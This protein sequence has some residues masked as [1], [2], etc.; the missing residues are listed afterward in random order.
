M[1][2]VLFLSCL[3]SYIIPIN[4]KIKQI[5]NL[6]ME[7]NMEKKIYKMQCMFLLLIALL[8]STGVLAQKLVTGKVTDK[9]NGTGIP[10]VSIVIVGTSQGTLTNI[11]GDYSLNVPSD[12]NEITFSMIGFTPQTIKVGE[13]GII[14]VILQSTSIA[15]EGIV[16]TG[17]GG[18]VKRSKLTNS[19]AT[20]KEDVFKI[21]MHSNPAQA[22]SGE[23]SGLKVTQSSGKPGA[24]PVLVLRGGTNF[25][26]TG[27][28]L[29]MVDG[30]VRGSL[31]DINPEDIESM[32]VLKDAG[33]T[34]LYGARA[35]NGVVLITTKKGKEGKSE[36]SVK[37][38]VGFNY[39][40]NPYEFMKAEDYLSYA[41]TAV[42]NAGRLYQKT[43]GSWTGYG[44]ANSASLTANRPYGV[45]NLY[46]DP[47]NPTVPLDG[48]KTAMA[49]WSPML[50][51][52]DLAFL[53]DQGYKKMTDPVTGSEIIYSEFD[54]STTAFNNP[55]MT[56][57]YYFSLSGGN[58]KGNYY[59]GLG[60]Y[61]EKGLPIDTYY[62]RLN[63]TFNGD[64]KLR[65]WLTS[66]SSFLF[67]GANWKDITNTSEANYFA[68]MLS[69]P[70]TQREYNASGQLLLG[71]NASDGN[72]LYN[73]DKYIRH[74]N[75]D[76]VTFAQSL[77]FDIM[78]GL[79]LKVN[80]NW[81][82]DEGYYESFD[83]DYLQSP[84]VMNTTRSSSASFD[85]TIRQTYNT[86][87]NYT[88]DFLDKHSISALV[89]G[90]YYDSY[91]KGLAASGSGASTDDFADLQYTSKKE[92]MR[93]TDTYHI[94]ERILSAFGRVN[95][96]YDT[97]YLLSLTF[98]ED[99]YSKLLGDNRWGFFPGVSAGWVFS[100]ENFMQSFIDVVN[101]AKLRASYGL[102]GN[103]SGIGPYTLQGSYVSG[104]YNGTSSFAIGNVAIPTFRWERSKTMEFGV[105][106]GF[107]KGRLNTNI[108]YYNRL[109]EDK[110][111]E[112]PLPSSSGLTSIASNNGEFRN[113]GVEF[114]FTAKIIQ[115]QDW[116]WEAGGNISY[117][118]NM[119]VKLPN[120]GLPNNRQGAIQVYDP[121]SGEIIYVGGY[122]EG[123]RPGD[124]YAF[125]AQGIYKDDA[126]VLELAGNLTDI[127][128]G[129]NGSTGKTLYGPTIWSTL[130]D[131]QKANGHPI[132]PGDVIWK[133]VN[134]DGKID[135]MDMEK[136]GNSTPKWLGGFNTKVSWK[137]LSLSAR[138]DYAL[139]FQQMDNVTPW[140]MGMMQGTYNSLLLT[141]D[142]WT[143]TNTGAEYPRY[144]WA[145]QLG[146]RNYARPSSMFVYN[147]SY[148]AF[149]EVSLTYSLPSD[150]VK[151]YKFT[152][153]DVSVT[154][155]NLGYL[156]NSKLYSPE[157]GGSLGGGY[158]LPRSVV[159]GLNLR[160]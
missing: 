116:T 94:R 46:W 19:I 140:F 110:Y 128:S 42:Y 23:V 153:V 81:M 133:D 79:N 43:D 126:Q 130:T 37:A 146:K 147:G 143:P 135:N 77:K 90:E 99:G 97:K 29:I 30:Q 120:N 5:I 136:V 34:A 45:G 1:N 32:E 125:I 158:P 113:S 26:G 15:L 56:Q 73:L 96:D 16:V 137:G 108:T 95:Y 74:N 76:K 39:L 47:A 36:L 68:R 35:N 12:I 33:A 98:R 160:F 71:T 67:N 131:A 28:P 88:V 145:D 155:Q 102:N 107:L 60:Y 115:K 51:T 119:V 121:N 150:L 50:Y 24:S 104:Q 58:E 3:M 48:N 70:P 63:F 156:S 27:S 11:D 114:D 92:G 152:G 6:L 49:I 138:M 157:V 83:K 20:V 57:D 17:Y 101:F 22:L 64:Y 111:A 151:K 159:F 52:P 2:Y 132:Q 117:N 21:G 118:K 4:R 65:P 82:Y 149:R 40:N 59:A 18:V 44:A 86:V 89:G 148:L 8:L 142:T 129:N 54:R 31:S 127:S 100:K 91:S 55:A 41:R 134:G 78:K 139:G 75:T 38:R 122:Q 106:L 62:K 105:D 103:V 87:L 141:K 80:G 25:D 84:G 10:G 144:L 123:Q 9:S 69:A 72:P 154:G 109:T 124:M 14:N 112:I 85:R 66:S 13:S 53:L 61:D 93:G 7:M